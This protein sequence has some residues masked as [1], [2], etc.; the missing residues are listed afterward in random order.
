[1]LQPLAVHLLKHQLGRICMLCLHYGVARL[2]VSSV[3]ALWCRRAGTVTPCLQCMC[4]HAGSHPRQRRA[5]RLGT[6]ARDK[7]N[8]ECASS[9]LHVTFASVFGPCAWHSTSIGRGW[10]AGGPML[11]QD[12]LCGT[13]ILLRTI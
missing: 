11:A 12:K 10:W 9:L 7:V 4:C 5:G 13:S 6:A 3:H 8:V 2:T 1:M